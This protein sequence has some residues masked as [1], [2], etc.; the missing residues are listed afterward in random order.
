MIIHAD[1]FTGY[2]EELFLCLLQPASLQY[3][4]AKTRCIKFIQAFFLR[5]IHEYTGVDNQSLSHYLRI[6]VDKTCVYTYKHT[7]IFNVVHP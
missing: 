7:Q 1:M 3:I 5:N 2:L 4:Y 6:L